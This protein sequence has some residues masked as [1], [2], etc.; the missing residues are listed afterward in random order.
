[1]SLDLEQLKTVF[2]STQEELAEIFKGAF[3]I[4]ATFE[5][6]TACEPGEVLEGADF[7]VPGVL[8]TAIGPEAAY[9][10]VLRE[11]D[12]LLADTYKSSDPTDQNIIR[13]LAQEIGFTLLPESLGATSFDAILVSDLAKSL[14]D[15]GVSSDSLG[16]TY[17][18][19]VGEQQ[20]RL[21]LVGPCPTIEAIAGS[22][23]D[24]ATE[25]KMTAP[26]KAA[27][28]NDHDAT[29]SSS[30]VP[31][32]DSLP[33][34]IDSAIQHLPTYTKSLLRINVPVTVKL[35]SIKQPVKR[36][37]EMNMGSII[38]FDK[39]CEEPLVLEVAGHEVAFGEA[40]KVGDKF[41]LRITSVSLPP[42]R[43]GPIQ[44]MKES[45]H[46]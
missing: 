15:A 28:A 21:D 18:A 32:R 45:Q 23:A 14:Q 39:S 22:S 17:S 38:Q 42:E 7:T 11:G 20:T 37:V 44:L 29:T 27:A 40:V 31:S 30:R 46:E 1:M 43:F 33:S 8:L 34:D 13:T 3:A 41:G 19:Q 12:G 2:D 35:A 36:V 6:V 25:P 16:A 9:A 4:E 5:S 10:F 24:A 26:D